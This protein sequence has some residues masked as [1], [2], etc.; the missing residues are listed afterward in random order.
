MERSWKLVQRT[1]GGFAC[2]AFLLLEYG[3]PNLLGNRPSTP[4]PHA[5]IRVTMVTIKIDDIWDWL[6]DSGLA[7]ENADSLG[8]SN[9]FRIGH[10]TQV[11][12][13]RVHPRAVE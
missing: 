11:G 6:C 5:P 10:M 7:S 4:S 3:M 9:W 2:S 12:T 1:S 13:I 8:H